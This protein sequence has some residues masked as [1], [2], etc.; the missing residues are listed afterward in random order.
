VWGVGF[1]DSVEDAAPMDPARARAGSAGVSSE[2]MCVY[3]ASRATQRSLSLS[4]FLSLSLALSLSIA[5]SLARALFR[6]L[7]LSLSSLCVIA[8][9]FLKQRAGFQKPPGHMY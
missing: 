8:R 7:S 4:Q 6:A 9:A 5:L 2:A 1:R 3:T